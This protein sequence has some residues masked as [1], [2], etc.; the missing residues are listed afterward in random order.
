[1]EHRKKI[2]YHKKNSKGHFTSMEGISPMKNRLPTSEYK[3]NI[4][5]LTEDIN[6]DRDNRPNIDTFPSDYNDN[7]TTS[8]DPYL[9]CNNNMM[10]ILRDGV[11]YF[12][13][14]K[15]LKKVDAVKQQMTEIEMLNI[16]LDKLKMYHNEQKREYKKVK[17]KK[18]IN[19]NGGNNE[20]INENDP[21][22]INLQKSVLELEVENGLLLKEINSLNYKEEGNYDTKE[23][24]RFI[25]DEINRMN[26][27]LYSHFRMNT[28][29]NC[30]PNNY[31]KMMQ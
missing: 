16:E 12:N 23:M 10:N 1:M 26:N 4:Y 3:D 5:K 15:G 19:E 22:I 13:K 9:L 8:G 31:K 18:S 24:K 7:I 29:N 25:K 27:L 21:Y 30:V 28:N 20:I 2:T 17:N 6:N 11:D 14:A